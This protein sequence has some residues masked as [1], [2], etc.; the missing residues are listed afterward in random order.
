LNFD[1]AANFYGRD[2]QRGKPDQND[3]AMAQTVSSAQTGGAAM[4][5]RTGVGD[6]SHGRRGRGRVTGPRPDEVG[7]GLRGLG[8]RL[9][10]HRGGSVSEQTHSPGLS[11]HGL[12]SL[13]D[14]NQIFN[15]NPSSWA[16]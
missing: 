1:H 11:S 10:G 13:N 2:E 12:G 15:A 8:L 14:P 9:G 16:H 3:Q 7:L 4:G 5:G 6:H